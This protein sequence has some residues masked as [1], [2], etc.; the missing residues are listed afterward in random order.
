MTTGMAARSEPRTPGG[1]S[2][3]AK[4]ALDVVASALVA[5][6]TLPVLLL[7]IV[8]LQLASPG[9]VLYTQARRG[10]GGR[11]FRLLKLRTMR[12]GADEAL[13]DLCGKDPA[14]RAEWDRYGRLARDPRVIP[15]VG[16]LVRRLSIDE[17]PQLWN[18]IRA[19]MSLVGPRPLQD[20]LLDDLPSELVLRRA[21]VRP[22]L[23]GLW[24]VSGRSTLTLD[25]ML[26]VDAVYVS[27]WRLGLDLRILLR[28]PGAVLRGEGAY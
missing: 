3:L 26:A 5:V 9:P 25:E 15:G 28:T 21:S 13:A 20:A 2:N 8:A 17:L 24:Q 27:T 4:R 18:V 7:A 1:P 16:V 19:E 6:A 11:Q 12:V 23:T 22:G 14:V 10:R